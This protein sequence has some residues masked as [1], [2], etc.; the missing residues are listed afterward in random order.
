MGM[1]LALY[2]TMSSLYILY[3]LRTTPYNLINASLL[4]SLFVFIS[5]S[6]SLLKNLQEPIKKSAV[7]QLQLIQV[8]IYAEV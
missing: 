5:D 3:Q 4:A 7:P 1:I 8:L 6:F 2:I